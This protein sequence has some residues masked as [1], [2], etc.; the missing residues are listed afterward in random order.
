MLNMQLIMICAWAMIRCR[1]FAC[2]GDLASKHKEYIAKEGWVFMLPPGVLTVLGFTL[3]WG[4][5][6]TLTFAVLTAYV[7]WFFRN[8]YRQIPE[9][10]DAIVS[11]ADGKV[12]GIHQMDDG[13]QLI[14][15]F[16]NVFN[17][18]INR[19]PIKGTVEEVTYTEG[20]FVA[21]YEENASEINERNKLVISDGDFRVEVTQIA[22]LIA[23]RIIC[24]VSEST[25]LA[26]G[27]RFGLIR[28]G[29]RMDI[30]LP[31]ECEIVTRVG[32]KTVGGSMV[33]A[34]RKRVA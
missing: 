15:I 25:N 14:T 29:S 18:H 19:S 22:G 1:I 33:I 3:G 2:E 17:V 13:R 27:E 11:P 24:W 34:R 4:L 20:L 23:R 21:A 26:K 12:V 8:P 7:A 32:E 9:D 30:V 5:A 31:A 28:F 10:P 6:L 16:L